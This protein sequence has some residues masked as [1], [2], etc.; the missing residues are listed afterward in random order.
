MKILKIFG[1]DGAI[2]YTSSSQIISAIGGLVTVFLIA[3]FMTPAT[4]GFYFTFASVLAIQTFFEL[5]LGGIINQFTAHEM[6]YLKF[7]SPTR[8]V[9]EERKLSR[10][11][12]LM[13]FCLKWYAIAAGLMFVC[14]ISVGFWYFNKFGQQYPDVNWQ[15][16]WILVSLGASLNLV[17]SPW[18]AVLQGMSKVKEMAKISFIKQLIILTVTW[19]SL[20]LG[21]KLYIP[22]I[23]SLTGFIILILLYSFTP[24]PKL[25]LN[26]FKHKIKETISYRYEIFPLQWKIAISWVSGYFIFQF[27]NPVVFAYNGAEAAG[28]V[29][30]TLTVLNAITSFVMSWISTKVPTWSGFIARKEYGELDFSFKKTIQQSTLISVLCI[31]VFVVFI[32]V[33]N[34]LNMP[35]ANRFLPIFLCVIVFLTIPFNNIVSGSAT[36]L[37]CHKKEPF[38]IQSIIIGVLTGISTFV[39]AKY[40]GVNGVIIGYSLIIIFISFP[41]SLYIFKHFRKLYHT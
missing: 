37:R 3:K 34:Y 10:L 29:G 23:N 26:T 1:I 35:L 31:I 38:L 17:I 6:A 40:L 18:M 25:L 8:L 13:H 19:L 14:L 15:L 20:A 4:Q 36:Y 41:S 11:S 2:F 24:Y 9:G 28:K 32:V 33:I 21:A 39:G 30:M 16:P 27:F 22:A 12:S 7:F 5:G